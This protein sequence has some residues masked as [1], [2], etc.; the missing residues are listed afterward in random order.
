MRPEPE[1]ELPDD[2]LPLSREPPTDE[3]ELLPEP[4]D[5]LASL[6]PLRLRSPR[7]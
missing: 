4:R 2:P 1:P 5:V 7:V 3:P 6:P